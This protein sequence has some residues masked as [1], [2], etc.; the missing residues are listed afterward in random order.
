MAA[1]Y[2]EI[3][4]VEMIIGNTCMRLVM[5][6]EQ[7]GVIVTT[8]L[9]GDIISNLCAG[10]AGGLGMARG[11]NIGEKAAISEAVYGSAPD[12]AGKGFANPSA[13]THA[14]A[15]MLDHLGRP[16]LAGKTRRAIRDTR[17]AGDRLT[18]DLGDGAS[19]R[20]FTDAVVGR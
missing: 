19:T 13:L 8:N 4:T 6:P 17:T 11:A 5:Q 14:V 3:E 9:F 12:I 16:E 15:R 18:R 20:K 2:P 10:L 1:E 7:F